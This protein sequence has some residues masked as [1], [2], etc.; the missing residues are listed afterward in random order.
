L[1]SQ[2]NV[3]LDTGSTSAVGGFA[4]GVLGCTGDGEVTL[5]QGWN[6]YA[7]SDATQIGSAQYDFET[8]VVHE[9]GHALGL[10]HSTTTGSVMYPTLDPGTA[11]RALAT[12]DLNMAD[13]S[14]G[15]DGLHA[16]VLS[17]PVSAWETGFVNGDEK[18][19]FQ[20]RNRVDSDLFFAFAGTALDGFPIA[21][22]SEARAERSGGVGDPR[23]AGI[24]AVFAR[25]NEQPIFAGA[26]QRESD[27]PL[28]AA[29]N[30]DD[31]VPADF[32]W[33]ES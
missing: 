25:V 23:R 3:V 17:N 29:E 9:L 32:S 11:N 21:A 28:L 1:A 2:A 20:G 6:W 15:A 7:G 33:Q 22:A 10:G 13:G 12:A 27:D 26:S 18:P 4:D 24:D 19:S 14:S 16:G 30:L 5:I 8:V 31:Y